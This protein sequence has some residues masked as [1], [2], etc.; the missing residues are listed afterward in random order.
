MEIT[1]MAGRLAALKTAP[2]PDFDEDM[3]PEDVAA[4][5]SPVPTGNAQPKLGG[6]GKLRVAT[7]ASASASASADDEEPPKASAD[8]ALD[9]EKLN[10]AILALRGTE[11][12]SLDDLATFS[13]ARSFPDL[14]ANG[15]ASCRESVCQYV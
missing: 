3:A 9:A 13:E 5:P 11:S 14:D 15:R 2:Q 6:I 1:T 12:I 4:S 10:E 8:A 7:A